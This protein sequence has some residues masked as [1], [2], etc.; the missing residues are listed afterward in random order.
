MNLLNYNH[1]ISSL[2]ILSFRVYQRNFVS[3]LFLTAVL[4][5]PAFLIGIAGWGESE[6]IIFFLSAHILEGAITLGIIGTTFGGFFPSL[7]ILRCFRSTFFLGTI[8]VAIIQY[9]LFIIGVMGLT[10]PFPFSIIIVSL[11]LVGLL[12]TSMAQPVF[13][14]EGIRGIN[15]LI[16]SIKLARTNLS[17]VFLVVVLSTI[18]QFFLFA[19]IMVP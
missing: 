4:M 6:S 8:H 16:R 3:I 17:R 10:L 14:V 1:S 2:F 13:A 5:A 19:I 11:W 12:M 18:L 7:G 15:A 9:L